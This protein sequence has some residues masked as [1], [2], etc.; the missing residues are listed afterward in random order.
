[1]DDSKGT[2]KGLVEKV[3]ALRLH[4]EELESAKPTRK[5]A[6]K[7]LRESESKRKILLENL[8]QRI[9]SKD[10][11]LVYVSCNENFARDLNIKP[12][13]ITGKTDYDFFPEELAEKYRADDKRIIKSGKTEDIE[14]KY[15]LEGQEMIVHT[16]KTPVKDEQGSVV[17]LLGIF[18][19]ITDRKRAEEKLKQAAEEWISTF[20][21]IK[22]LVWV[23]DKNFKLVKV[24]KAFAD[25]FKMEP[26]EL[27]GKTCYEVVHGTKHPWPNCP[28]KQAIETKK[29]VTEEIFEP[30]LGIH[31]QLSTSPVL[32]EEGEVTNVVHIAKD[33]TERKRAEE[34]LRKAHDELEMRVEERTAELAKANEE[35]RSEITERKHVEKILRE[36]EKL[37][38]AGRLA[39]RI[40]H[41]INNP[42]AAIKNSFLLI[43]DAIGQ[44]HP[45]YQYVGRI[46]KEIS[47]VSHIVRQMFDLYRPGGESPHKFRLREVITDVVALLKVSSRECNVNIEVDV[48]GDSAVVTLNEGLFRQ[49]LFNIIQNAIEASPSD[50]TVKV[51]ADVSDELLTVKVAD[52]GPGI[53]EDI[54]DNIFEPFFSTKNGDSTSG[55][56]LGLSVCKGIVDAMGGSISFECE[57]GRGTIFSIVTPLPKERREAKNG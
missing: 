24:N 21:S 16:V 31:L 11:Y 18:W 40:A 44:D 54:R 34:A 57:K 55:L 48:S 36:S 23:Q 37:A 15:I 42:L 56:G 25:T 6:E 1:M 5:Q 50:E 39:A 33:I 26:E 52:R 4:P 47:R 35:L 29:S 7:A 13:E 49:V 53:G 19:D 3:R 14:E 22:D 8:P 43:K 20:N 30:H 46:D 9:F 17:G 38:A 45:Y 28:H 12:E 41:E 51:S 27:I 2:K 32:N 10:K